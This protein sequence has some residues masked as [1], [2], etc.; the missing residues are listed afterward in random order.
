VD[1]QSEETIKKFTNPG[2]NKDNA[3]IRKI[4]ELVCD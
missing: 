2:D 3:T 4:R 1:E